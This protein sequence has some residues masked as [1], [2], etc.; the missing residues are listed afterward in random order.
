M[1]RPGCAIRLIE[2]LFFL[3]RNY[4]SRTFFEVENA[5]KREKEIKGWSRNKKED[6]IKLFNP[7]WNFLN[8][9]I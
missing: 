1:R 5:I 9:E 4:L 7:Q 8:R 6:L 3:H 2:T